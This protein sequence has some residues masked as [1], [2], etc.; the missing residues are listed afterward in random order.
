MVV[1][2]LDHNIGY[3]LINWELNP[4]STCAVFL[5]EGLGSIRQWRDFPQKFCDQF[6][7][8]GL[9]YDRVGYGTSSRMLEN[10]TNDYMHQEALN[11]LP[12]L[13]KKL[14]IDN[15]ILV[16][17][18]DGASIALIHASQYPAKAV[19]SMAAHVF[20]EEIS[21]AGIQEA[22]IEFEASER[23]QQA[24]ER[25]HGDKYRTLFYAWSDTW[26]TEAFRKWNIESL[27]SNIRCPILAI[28]G[29]EDQYGTP[30]QV[31]SIVKNVSGFAVSKMVDNCG[32]A[33]HSEQ[34]QEVVEHCRLFLRDIQIG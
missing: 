24:L 13:L 5:H 28:Q 4:N 12:E 17:H 33:P 32:H 21:V 3:E 14:S 23:F 9:V 20:V 29:K 30:A 15:Y 6:Q 16:G 18:S 22:T 31:D 7:M 34:E 1:Q 11:V 25:Y 26:Q 10:R 8:K 27:L 2:V 19:V